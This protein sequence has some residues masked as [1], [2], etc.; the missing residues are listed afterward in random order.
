MKTYLSVDLDYWDKARHR[1]ACTRF[2]RQVL[3]LKVPTLVVLNHDE[4]W[5]DVN[6]S[7]CRR[8][9]HVDYHSDVADYPES[10]TEGCKDCVQCKDMIFD[11]GTWLSFVR[12]RKQGELLWRFPTWKCYRNGW[13]TCHGV[14]DPFKQPVSGWGII[15]LRHGLQGIPWDDVTRV[16]IAVSYDY[17][18]KCSYE[19]VLPE[20]LG[21][22][23]Y[24]EAVEIAKSGQLSEKGRRIRRAA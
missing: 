15:G 19:D 20:L 14:R 11:E 21:V 12:W 2:I 9:E 4:M 6:R 7:G 5:G 24:Q 16:G 8:V 3:D 13:G 1:K 22:G 23:T 10:C 18:G 17:W